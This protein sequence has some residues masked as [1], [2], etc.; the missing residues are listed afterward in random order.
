M[1]SATG[2]SHSRAF[3]QRER[4]QTEALK[5]EWGGEVVDKLDR[6]LLRQVL[7]D[8]KERELEAWIGEEDV[9][10]DPRQRV[11]VNLKGARHHPEPRVR[12]DDK[13][14]RRR[15]VARMQRSA[16]LSLS[17]VEAHLR[18]NDIEVD[19][20]FW[21]TQ[22]VVAR[23]TDHELALVAAREDVE[24]VNADRLYYALHLDVSRPLI[25]ADQVQA[26]L[27]LDGSGVDVAVLDTGIDLTHVALRTVVV[28]QQS[29]AP[30][31]EG[32]GDNHGHGTHCA[33]IVASQDGNRRG[34]APGVRLWDVK[35]M[36]SNGLTTPIH[37]VGGMQAAV[38]AGVDVASNSWGF[39]NGQGW[40]DLNGSCV[41]C[42][43][44]DNAVAAGVVFCVAAGN[45]NNDPC[46]LFATHIGCPGSARNVVTVGASDDADN[47]AGFSSIG[48][49]P[50]GRVKPDV[51]APGVG[52]A[53]ARANGTAMGAPID[54]NW[55]N[56]NGTSMACPHVA[57]VAAL[58]L[59]NNGTLTPA[60]V[61]AILMNT[62][63]DIGEVPEQMGAGRVDALAAVNAS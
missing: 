57:G 56:A 7:Y 38:A 6:L 24:S 12:P 10:R 54:A 9:P 52:I 16:E 35:I 8:R 43:A 5:L 34:V 44:A 28:S 51:T 33:G 48:P 61:K 25:Q 23:V 4:Q 40:I 19:G 55:T 20:R 22:S 45:D 63:V 21:L 42:I 11:L 41:L 31:F 46:F 58:M 14:R 60:Q 30:F 3:L 26:T 37:A 18:E 62:A 49:T 39:S 50:D 29:F 2:R 27:G 1:N 53:S 36:D 13:T 59:E 47:M 15:T 32:V 17:R